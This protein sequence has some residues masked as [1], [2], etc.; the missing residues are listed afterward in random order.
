[1]NSFTKELIE[2]LENI[3]KRLQNKELLEQDELEILFIH[4]LLE[5]N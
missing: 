4:S 1:M 2:E 3:K 5:E